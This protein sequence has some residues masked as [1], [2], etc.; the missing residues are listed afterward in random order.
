[1]KTYIDKYT[2]L[3]VLLFCLSMPQ[4]VDGQ[5]TSMVQIRTYDQNI[6]LVPNINV[7]INEGEFV[8]SGKDGIFY[9]NTPQQNMPPKKV[10]I[11]NNNYEA[12][13]WNYSNG[14]LDIIIRV[15]SYK[16]I[17]AKV[18]EDGAPARN[19]IVQLASNSASNARTDSQGQFQLKVPRNVDL[20]EQGNFIIN[21]YEVMSSQFDGEMVIIVVEKSDVLRNDPV[22]TPEYRREDI[23]VTA[24]DL[25]ALDT[26]ISI[27][28]F[29]NVIK[30]EGFANIGTDQ[31]DLVDNK[32]YELLRK[33]EDSV[34]LKASNELINKISETSSVQNDI[35][36]LIELAEN[37]KLLLIQEKEDFDQKIYEIQKKL[38]NQGMD[39]SE[40]ERTVILKDL[41][42]LV[43]VLAMNESRFSQ[44]QANY[45]LIMSSLEGFLI[46]DIGNL[47]YKLAENE[48]LRIEEKKAFQKRL[49]IILAAALLLILLAGGSIYL[50]RKFN[51]Q[52]QEIFEAHAEV[53]SVN[54]HLE[55]LVEEKTQSL[56]A[57]NH[58]LDTFL[59]KSSHDLRRPL[60]SIRGLANIA[61]LTL[62]E[63]AY[64]LFEKTL[65]TANDM[66]KLLNKLSTV[67]II[68]NPEKNTEINV[69]S[70]LKLVYNKLPKSLV[71]AIH[72]N[73]QMKKD[74]I[75]TSNPDIVDMILFNLIENACKFASN[76]GNDTHTVSLK[77]FKENS[78]LILHIKDN[79]R[80]INPEI[81]DKIWNMF[82]IGSDEIVT[83]HGLGLYITKKAVLTLGGSIELANGEAGSTEFRVCIPD[84]ADGEIVGEQPRLAM[85]GNT[86]Q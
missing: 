58:E 77:I 29:Y 85:I 4:W 47:E 67:S 46:D 48:K 33:S 28:D 12:A 73:L 59:Y 32:F 71:G 53:K 10:E 69:R 15:K 9:L 22:Q 41:E 45:R 60:S 5:D 25:S 11:E 68:N 17:Q 55:E 1:M 21:G 38:D 80:G 42:K 76:S 31:Q 66:D 36:V 61:R 37:D 81:R 20:A 63:E 64:T 44:N 79:G 72:F 6:Q 83:G 14:R 26:I 62:G 34:Q 30:G 74:L 40:D 43:E 52:K 39:L 54:D 51:R 18:T 49:S 84:N 57:T 75:F 86:P 8:N 16:I 2:V 23:T 35:S 82:Y 56:L 70:H 13:S 24:L 7:S 78:S 27:T 50:A 19:V 3:F 65:D